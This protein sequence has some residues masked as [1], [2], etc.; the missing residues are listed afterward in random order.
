M[1]EVLLPIELLNR[2]DGLSFSFKRALA[3]KAKYLRLLENIRREPITNQVDIVVVRILGKGQRLWDADSI[4]RGSAKQLIDALVDLN[5]FP[6]DGPR[7]IRNCDYRQCGDRR[8]E[9]PSVLIRI[10]STE[11]S[12]EH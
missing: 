3:I 4:G 2:N 8:S 9:G 12:G 11:T 6:D 10:V 1:E 5:W 7:W